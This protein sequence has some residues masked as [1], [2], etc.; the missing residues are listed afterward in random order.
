MLPG[1]PYGDV[2][3]FAEREAPDGLVVYLEVAEA[4]A[5]WTSRLLHHLRYAG[6]LERANGVLVGRTPGGS[7]DGFSQLD[8]LH[9]ALDGLPV[10][11]LYDVDTGHVPPQL[12]LVNGASAVVE[13]HADGHGTLVQTLD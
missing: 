12:A 1:T 11:V 2:N 13:L 5:A 6:W 10:P 4:D 8:A 3:A 9:H 7:S